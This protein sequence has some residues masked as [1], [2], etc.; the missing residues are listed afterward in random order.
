MLH[1]TARDIQ[2]P[3]TVK[4]CVNCSNT[5]NLDC[6][7]HRKHFECRILFVWDIDTGEW[8]V[9]DYGDL[10]EVPT[11]H[12][13]DR[14]SSELHRMVK[15]FAADLI[16]GLGEQPELFQNVRV[17]DCCNEKSKDVLKDLENSIEFYRSSDLRHLFENNYT[18]SSDVSD[19][20]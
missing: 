16:D 14:N 10:H 19:I 18:Y 1:F 2:P 13:Y 3:N 9:Q 5:Q 7:F 4:P 12:G 20:D 15:K 17:L 8:N 11:I 6:V